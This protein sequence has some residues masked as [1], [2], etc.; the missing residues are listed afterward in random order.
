MEALN[1]NELRSATIL[2]IGLGFLLTAGFLPTS[3]GLGEALLPAPWGKLLGFPILALFFHVTMPVL[4]SY[5][6][7]SFREALEISILPVV[8]ALLFGLFLRPGASP[9]SARF[10]D[11][12]WYLL[13]APLGEELLFRGWVY[14]FIDRAFR[15]KRLTITNPLPV[16]LWVSAICFSLWH[17]Q[18]GNLFQVLYTFFTGLWLG[19][20]R[21]KTGKLT[22]PVIGHL[23]INLV[24]SI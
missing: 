11:S 7:L 8:I 16:A 9:L 23:A 21:W 5:E 2:T 6:R 15:G 4:R 10:P 19:Y 14:S 12:L 24:A 22:A 1:R 18:D 3:A 20:L 17:L 13:F